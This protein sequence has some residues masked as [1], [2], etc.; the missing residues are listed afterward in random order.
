MCGV[1]LIFLLRDPARPQVVAA[2]V[3]TK[4]FPQFGVFIPVSIYVKA[5]AA[6]AALR[7]AIVH[8]VLQ[9]SVGIIAKRGANETQYDAS[10]VRQMIECIKV[11]SDGKLT[12]I[13]GGGYEMEEKL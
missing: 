10:I 2:Q 7:H 13:F 6:L 11:H 4:L 3:I 8:K 5:G 9:V 12:L 1:A